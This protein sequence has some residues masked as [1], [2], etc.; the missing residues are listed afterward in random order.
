MVHH[1]ETW[2]A[3]KKLITC[4]ELSITKARPNLESLI[5]MDHFE[6]EKNKTRYKWQ[7][8]HLIVWSFLFFFLISC[9]YNL[10]IRNADIEALVHVGVP[11]DPNISDEESSQVTLVDKNRIL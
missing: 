3:K 7:C 2:N 6:K 4:R 1:D 11:H 10:K 8:L 5:L 9:T